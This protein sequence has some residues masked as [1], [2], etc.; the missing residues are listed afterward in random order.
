[1]NDIIQINRM[2]QKR[3]YMDRYGI[4]LWISLI[5]C[6]LFFLAIGYYF[7]NNNLKSLEKNWSDIQ[8]N[9]LVMPFAGIIHKEKGLTAA[10]YTQ[11]NFENCT[12]D[13]LYPISKV[14]LRPLKNIST[15]LVKDLR[16]VGKEMTKTNSKIDEQQEEVEEKEDSF[17][18]GV[19]ERMNSSL[20]LLRKFK[21][22]ASKMNGVTYLLTY[23]SQGLIYLIVSILNNL[24]KVLLKNPLTKNIIKCFA[25]GTPIKCVN[26]NTKPIENICSG[27]ILWNGS[28]VTSTMILSSDAVTFYELGGSYV[29]HNH[30]VFHPTKGWIPV[31]KHP[32]ANP[33]T[34][35][36]PHDHIYCFNTTSKTIQIGNYTFSDWDDLDDKDLRKL[37]Q[38]FPNVKRNNIHIT[39]DNGYP[40]ANK[41]SLDS[42][43]AVKLRDL[44]PGYILSGGEKIYGIVKMEDDKYNLLTYNGTFILN[45]EI[46]GDYNTLI[47]KYL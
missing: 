12:K 41:I 32:E 3:G 19:K 37:Q 28:I 27:D 35:S 14:S 26:G 5:T 17:N 2:Y 42:G 34:K 30:N 23:Q 4:Q 21:E 38:Y 9:P 1:M 36:Y 20:I 10:E 46:K 24:M 11:K 43:V 44:K 15:S 8:C 13:S 47:E 40:G 45:G 7:V 29:T 25:K 22:L 18:D 33:I 16:S 6:V 39:F 31:C